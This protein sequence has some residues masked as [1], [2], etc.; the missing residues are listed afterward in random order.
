MTPGTHLI[1]AAET[2]RL[3]ESKM[4]PPSA[5][6]ARFTALISVS[7]RCETQ[8][9]QTTNAIITRQF[10]LDSGL[11]EL[12]EGPGS[13]LRLR[14]GPQQHFTQTN[15]ES[16]GQGVS[17]RSVLSRQ[18]CLPGLQDR[19]GRGGPS[20]PPSRKGERLDCVICLCR[21]PIRPGINRGRSWPKRGGGAALVL[22]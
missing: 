14:M 6:C 18:C 22:M 1:L 19:E 5:S 12:S 8:L 3:P 2:L 15:G 20:S 17:G 4:M 10:H 7:G 11:G 16:S 21:A 13:S 9:L